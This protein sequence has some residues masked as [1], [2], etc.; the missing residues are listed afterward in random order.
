MSSSWECDVCGYVYDEAAEGTGWA[1]LPDDWVCPICGASKA[2][3]SQ[4]GS[5]PEPAAEADDKQA[6]DEGYLAKWIRH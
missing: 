2:Q 6:A 3:F 1:D 4:K 5:S